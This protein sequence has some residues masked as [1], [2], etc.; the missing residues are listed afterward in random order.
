MSEN[1]PNKTYFRPILI[2]SALFV[3][4]LAGLYFYSI[5]EVRQLDERIDKELETI[6]KL[7]INQIEQW[8]NSI[9]TDADIIMSNIPLTARIQK[10]MQSKNKVDK[11]DDILSWMK[12]TIFKKNYSKI[13]IY[14]LN[15]KPFL[16]FMAIDLRVK[17]IPEVYSATNKVL[18]S[19]LHKGDST[20][21]PHMDLIIPLIDRSSVQNKKFGYM[22]LQI[23]PE[24]FLYPLIAKW[25]VPSK[26][27]ETVILTRDNDEIVFLNKLR[28]IQKSALELRIK[29]KDYPNLPAVQAVTGVDGIVSG[30]DYRGKEVI[31]YVTKIKGTNWYFVAKEDKDE[32]FAPQKSLWENFLVGIIAV[33]I[34]AIISLFYSLRYEKTFRLK[35]ELKQELEK[36]KLSV[37][38][39]HL[40]KH[41]NDAFII[42]GTDLSIV[43]LNERTKIQY[44]YSFEEL[45]LIKITDLEEENLTE[46][47]S[48]KSKLGEIFKSG[49]LFESIHKTKDG[50][51]INVEISAQVLEFQDE[52]QLF[53]IIRDRT[54]RKKAEEAL[55]LSEALLNE[56]QLIAHIGHYNLNILTGIWQSSDALNQVFGIDWSYSTDIAG[57]VNLIY[58]ED[59]EMMSHYFANEVVGNKQPFDKEYRI[60][61]QSDGEI[62]WVH[63]LGKLNFDKDGN[64]YQMFGNIQDITERKKF[65]EAISLSESKFRGIF[66]NSMTVGKIY[67]SFRLEFLF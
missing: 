10:Y 46:N 66:E 8:R 48:I 64:P 28:H 60:I 43:D 45:I 51:K 36:R 55:K 9:L 34:V 58:P 40:A 14:D 30:N 21:L 47:T 65:N 26:T 25:P 44:G 7:K 52:K 16:S 2:V 67:N 59:Q 29:I 54:E 22:V 33:V 53:F 63:G 4:I 13:T 56:S 12:M 62:R 23:D 57:W 38:Y 27:A 42:T 49:T 6:A 11:G 35:Q 19:E 5:Q 31:A 15:I 24:K 61:R 41:A 20:E 1:I 37:K 32:I 3:A 39:E 18:L 50:R 17:N